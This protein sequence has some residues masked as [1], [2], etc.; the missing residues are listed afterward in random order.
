MGM[1]ATANAKTKSLKIKTVG[2]VRTVKSPLMVSAVVRGK[3]RK[4]VFSLDGRRLHVSSKRPYRLGGSA[5]VLDARQL[6][7]GKHRVVVRA[8][9]GRGFR[10]T[11][12]AATT[13]RVRSGSVTTS[14][15]VV[16][17]PAPAAAPTGSPTWDGSADKYGFGILATGAPGIWDYPQTI[18]NAKTE[19]VNSPVLPGRKAFKFTV[20]SGGERTELNGKTGT[21]RFEEGDEWWFGD[22]LY[23]PGINKTIGWDL[24]SH[25][26]FAQWKND[27]TGSPPLE[28][29]RRG[30]GLLLKVNTSPRS[31]FLLVPEASL[32]NR[33]IKIEIRVRFSSSSRGQLEAWVDGKKKVSISAA[34]LFAGKWSYLKEG[35]YGVGRGNVVYWHGM[36]LGTSREAVIR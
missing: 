32:Y 27:G 29:D 16:K 24:N 2:K 7:K 10:S 13:I 15:P 26:T 23:V 30:K 1:S 5:G 20:N 36:R 11:R 9:F 21:T 4:V 22:V 6:G 31:E 14:L 19:V 28:L 34:T 33:S 12:V 18:G 8:Y 17:A 25:H 35:Q 3:P